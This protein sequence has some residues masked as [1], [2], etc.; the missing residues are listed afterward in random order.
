MSPEYLGVSDDIKLI[1]LFYNAFSLSE[2]QKEG[3]LIAQLVGELSGLL[4]SQEVLCLGIKAGA[5][6]DA[7]VFFSKL[8]TEDDVTLYML[9]PLAVKTSRQGQGL[10]TQLLNYSFDQLKRMNIDAVVTYGDPKYYERFGFKAVSEQVIAAPKPLSMPQGWMAKAL[11]K[12]ELPI[13][14]SRP[15]CVAPFDDQRYW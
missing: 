10:G 15:R 11:N 8:T 14:S 5:D 6:L 12:A 3:A 2:G 13:L 9:S 1:S 4:G 7:A